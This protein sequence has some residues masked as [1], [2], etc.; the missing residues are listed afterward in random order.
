MGKYVARV[1]KNIL[2]PLDGL[3]TSAY[4]FVLGLPKISTNKVC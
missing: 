4:K 3:L 1:T 2:K